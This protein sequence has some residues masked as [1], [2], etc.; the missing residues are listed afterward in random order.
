MFAIYGLH[1]F[2]VYSLYAHFLD[3]FIINGWQ[4]LSKAFSA[5]YGDDHMVFIFNLLM[6]YITLIDLNI[7]KFL[8]FWVKSHLI[9]VYD[10]FNILLDSVCC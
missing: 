5:I 1:Y 2:E 8:Q 10:L 3:K 4:I 9:M 6:W 7:G